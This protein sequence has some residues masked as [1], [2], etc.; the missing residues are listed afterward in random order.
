MLL[1]SLLLATGPAMTQHPWS[2][3]VAVI[4]SPSPYKSLSN[5]NL[6]IPLVGYEGRH[7]YL[8][9][10]AAGYYLSRSQAFTLSLAVQL[11]PSRL[12]TADARDPQIRQLDDRQFSVLGGLKGQWRSAAGH[13]SATLATDISGRHHGQ[14]AE[15]AWDYPLQMPTSALQLSPGV[16]VNYYSPD[17]ARY[18]FGVSADEAQRSGLALWQPTEAINPFVQLSVRWRMAQRWQAIASLRQMWL[19]SP[20]KNSPLVSGQSAVSAFAGISYRF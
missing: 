19:D 13:W 4:H 14:Y 11:A 12:N 15:L 17:Y 3:G 7:L 2:L 20:L 16:G 18:Y 5:Q 1:T 9:G 6:L 10:P 8:R